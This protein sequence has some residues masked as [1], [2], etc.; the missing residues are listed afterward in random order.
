MRFV[1]S[2]VTLVLIGFN[3]QAAREVRNG[4]GGIHIEGRYLT[5]YSAHGKVQQEVELAEAIPGLDLL[6]REIISLPLTNDTKDGLMIFL[7]ASPVRRYYRIAGDA[8]DPELRKKLVEDYSKLLGIPKDQVVIFAVTNTDDRSTVL[9]PEFYTLSPTEQ[10]AMIVHESMWLRGP[11]VEYKDVIRAEQYTQAYFENRQDPQ[12]LFPFLESILSLY[13]DD[14]YIKIKAGL[15]FDIRNK[16][17]PDE[18]LRDNRILMK[19]LLGEK[20]TRSALCNVKQMTDEYSY[21]DNASQ[22]L[23]Y[24]MRFDYARKASSLFY[25]GVTDALQLGSVFSIS[26]HD[27][28]CG[29]SDF[30]QNVFVSFEFFEVGTRIYFPVVNAKGRRLGNLDLSK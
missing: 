7:D 28:G 17:F 1:L 22:E 15:A 4:G 24:E 9:L 26:P 16:R 2:L 8:L 20:F 25:S 3:S 23:F 19:D 10:A 18:A 27:F 21:R 14:R 29:K 6:I 13:Q 5:Y 30:L 11:R 12:W